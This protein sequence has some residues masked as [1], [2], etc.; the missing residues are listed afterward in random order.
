MGKT[1]RIAVNSSSYT[2]EVGTFPSLPVTVTVIG[3][4]SRAEP[5][6]EVPRASRQPLQRQVWLQVQCRLQQSASS[7]A[8]QRASGNG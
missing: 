1:L 7:I 3:K 5:R 6:K 2:V 4:V 8:G